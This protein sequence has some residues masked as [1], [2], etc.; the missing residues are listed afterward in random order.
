M[1]NRRQFIKLIG[2]FFTGMGVFINPVAEEPRTVWAKASKIVL[3]KETRTENLFN[4]HPAHLDTRNLDLTPLEEFRTMGLSDHR[5]DVDKWQ[6]TTGGH[7]RDPLQLTYAQI[8]RMPSI[9]KNVL[10]I[11]PGVF[12][13]HA[14]WKGV[15]VAKLLEMSHVKPEATHVTFRGPGGIYQKTERFPIE[16][17]L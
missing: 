14:R 8:I 9:E 3:P 6:L 13:Y 11:C 17:P 10:L 2:G 5:V 12:A 4:R 1:K 16:C 7:V 15:S